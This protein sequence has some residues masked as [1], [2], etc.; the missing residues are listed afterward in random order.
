MRKTK[1]K[2]PILEKK[3]FD[4]LVWSDM[5]FIQLFLSKSL[6]DVHG[7]ITRPGRAVAR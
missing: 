6:T 7:H 3:A 4:I 5:G 1:G 2:E